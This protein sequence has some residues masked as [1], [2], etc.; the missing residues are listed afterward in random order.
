MN[1]IFAEAK[2]A[3][4]RSFRTA[5]LIII[6]CVLAVLLSACA[7]QGEVVT[8]RIHYDRTTG[9]LDITSP[10][11]TRI[12]ELK[13]HRNATTGEMDVELTDY[14]SH[15]NDAAIQAQAQTAMAQA[16]MFQFMATL[17]AQA[18]RPGLPLSAVPPSVV[19][20]DVG[21]R[22]KRANG[23]TADSPSPAMREPRGTV[24]QTGDEYSKVLR[25]TGR[26]DPH[27]EGKPEGKTD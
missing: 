17:T 11:D 24:P 15:A 7:T 12:G 1:S 23:G 16:Q 4:P 6:F 10:K 20:D 13:T 8:T 22:V 14:A 2:E 26:T 25:D 5:L 19:V 9:T 27:G 18:L 3:S 21:N